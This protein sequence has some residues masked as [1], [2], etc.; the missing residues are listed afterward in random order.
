MEISN[1]IKFLV[2]STLVLFIG[3]CNGSHSKEQFESTDKLFQINDNVLNSKITFDDEKVT[4][5][6]DLLENSDV[7]TTIIPTE[8][9]TKANSLLIKKIIENVEATT[10]RDDRSQVNNQTF[11]NSEKSEENIETAKEQGVEV[12][13]ETHIVDALISPGIP[14][15]TLNEKSLDEVRYSNKSALNE[16][17]NGTNSEEN[18]LSSS[19][20]LIDSRPKEH[21]EI[22]KI[23]TG[24]DLEESIKKSVRDEILI[25]NPIDQNALDV[26]ENIPDPELRESVARDILGDDYIRRTELNANINADA[27]NVKYE[28]ISP[29]LDLKE[30][31]N[32][33]EDIEY[34]KSKEEILNNVQHH[35]YEN[36]VFDVTTAVS[37]NESK[38]IDLEKNL[39]DENN[40]VYTTSVAP[41][42]D[43]KTETKN[44]VTESTFE[45][46]TTSKE[47]NVADRVELQ[48]KQ[49]KMDKVILNMP[50]RGGR[51]MIFSNSIINHDL[52]DNT[53]NNYM[54]TLAPTEFVTDLPTTEVISSLFENQN[55]EKTIETVDNSGKITEYHSS[56]NEIENSVY[57]K[58][59]LNY[60]D[61]SAEL[62]QQHK[63]F[64]TLSPIKQDKPEISVQ[65]GEIKYGFTTEIPKAEEGDQ[66]YFTTESLNVN[67]LNNDQH[68]TL[69][70]FTSKEDE[71]YNKASTS[72]EESEIENTS[73]MS[74]EGNESVYVD[75]AT[76][77]I[78]P[79]EISDSS[80]SDS[81]E[82]IENVKKDKSSTKKSKKKD[83]KSSSASDSSSEES[84][85]VE[86]FGEYENKN[87]KTNSKAKGRSFPLNSTPQLVETG[88]ELF[89]PVPEDS[90]SESSDSKE[91]HIIMK[92][93]S[94]K[95]EDEN[96]VMPIIANIKT[97]ENPKLNLLNPRL[98]FLLIPDETKK[99]PQLTFE[100]TTLLPLKIFK[101]HPLQP[102]VTDDIPNETNF[103]PRTLDEIIPSQQKEQQPAYEN[104]INQILETESTTKLIGETF[105]EAVELSKEINRNMNLFLD[106]FETNRSIST[107]SSENH[108]TSSDEIMA[109]SSIAE[110]LP[111]QDI[112]SIESSM[113]P[114][115]V[116]LICVSI[117]IM[118]IAV[119]V[120]TFFRF[121]TPQG[122]LDIEMQEQR[123]GKNYNNDH[124]DE[125]INEKDYNCCTTARSSSTSGI[126]DTSASCSLVTTSSITSRNK[127]SSP[128]SAS[129]ASKSSVV[130]RSISDSRSNNLSA[131]SV[132]LL[133]EELNDK[134]Y[135]K[136]HQK[137]IPAEMCKLIPKLQINGDNNFDDDDENL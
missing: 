116:V 74:Q 25:E 30:Q 35:E 92:K 137:T 105:T 118:I 4:L 28:T 40:S 110:A 48:E 131:Q 7:S 84:E 36:R 38:T 126:E 89:T 49:N 121:R 127:T 10:I 3:S 58:P 130:K 37:E 78:K 99:I 115:L 106:P 95:S 81:S 112:K 17:V 135:E 93:P 107:L 14:G 53:L 73:T 12:T 124:D 64:T 16:V 2:I 23:T 119:L 15:S 77:N 43:Y 59:F 98:K 13:T 56:E 129:S 34:K 86:K 88:I 102:V 75:H 67:D 122:V 9:T 134:E 113:N 24:E 31:K 70:N 133:S 104:E 61:E 96:T 101:S 63:V 41:E 109:A 11:N 132:S 29:D 85:S 62:V 87:S 76:I 108:S 20:N 103:A 45:T 128:I 26:L 125:T 80:D 72:T 51:A 44:E 90:V 5:P 69:K 21:I 71:Y 114:T 60:K 39:T 18:S 22:Q 19:K 33:S 123:N 50:E 83:D 117:V 54:S 79:K 97:T 66:I 91:E 55:E 57:V 1:K 52:I 82:E 100:T 68:H 47:L 27:I 111:N 46:T 65:E 136:Q 32:N 8:I 94:A 42:I 6:T 120:V